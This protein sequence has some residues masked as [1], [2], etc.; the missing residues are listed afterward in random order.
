MLN[1]DGRIWIDRLFEGLSDKGE[2][3]SPADGERIV[4][5]VA[6]PVGA[7]GFHLPEAQD[8]PMGRRISRKPHRRLRLSPASPTAVA[9][10]PVVVISGVPKWA[11][12]G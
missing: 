12:R 8:R 3:L 5:L 7:G 9:A 6:H 1:P 11:K 2:R 10:K 4:H